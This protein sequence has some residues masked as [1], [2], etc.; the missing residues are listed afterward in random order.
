MRAVY[1]REESQDSNTLLVAAVSPGREREAPSDGYQREILSLPRS[2]EP[3]Q[4]SDLPVLVEKTSTLS[5]S[6]SCSTLGAVSVEMS[7]TIEAR[8]MSLNLP[9]SC[10]LTSDSVE[11]MLPSL[12]PIGTSVD[13]PGQTNAGVCSQTSTS[14][15]L[16]PYTGDENGANAHQIDTTSAEEANIDVGSSP[17]SLDPNAST[18]H[19]QPGLLDNPSREEAMHELSARHSHTTVATH[20]EHDRNAV[21]VPLTLCNATTKT[22][23]HGLERSKQPGQETH[24]E[25]ER[26]EKPCVNYGSGFTGK[27]MASSV[28]AEAKEVLTVEHL[29]GQTQ[30]PL[31]SVNDE[32][33]LQ[34]DT[35]PLP[36]GKPSPSANPASGRKVMYGTSA[37]TSPE[38]T[39][40]RMQSPIN[41]KGHRL[42]ANFDANLPV[43][44]PRGATAVISH[45]PQPPK[46]QTFDRL[47]RPHTTQLPNNQS[48]ALERDSSPTVSPTP[49][50]Q[51]DKCCPSVGQTVTPAP[52]EEHS[53]KIAF[54]GEEQGRPAEQHLM[55]SCQKDH[56]GMACTGILG[57]CSQQPPA[58]TDEVAHLSA[59][60]GQPATHQG[61]DKHPTLCVSQP[62][63]ADTGRL[64]GPPLANS[65]PVVPTPWVHPEENC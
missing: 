48:P 63:K 10:D 33:V 51:P 15:D 22:K 40:R 29:C 36:I 54:S 28:R 13:P 31:T 24:I 57:R 47:H 21:S 60:V 34:T 59:S 49:H 7:A 42:A 12:D 20:A 46:S 58:T 19:T 9:T 35:P 45:T 65:D 62:G 26:P 41:L 23:P 5:K 38:C 37:A 17:L 25:S 39:R 61:L 2:S 53:E 3:P 44:H 52:R 11:Q 8:S 55:T 6:E 43:G 64:V 56:W 16:V 1:D 50:P 18:R 4:P 27:E 14:V 32:G 30:P